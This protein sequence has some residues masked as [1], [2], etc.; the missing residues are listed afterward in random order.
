MVGLVVSCQKTPTYQKSRNARVVSADQE[1]QQQGRDDAAEPDSEENPADAQDNAEMANNETPATGPAT[2]Q[3]SA[4]TIIMEPA[5]AGRYAPNRLQA[6]WVTDMNDQHLRTIS[7]NPG[8]RPQHLR[9]WQAA[10]GNQLDGFSGATIT[11]FMA[12]PETFSWDLLDKNGAKVEYGN[13]KIWFELTQSNT[14]ADFVDGD[15]GY[16][17]YSMVFSLS[18]EGFSVNDNNHPTFTA[19]DLVH[20]P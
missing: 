14:D 11:S 19:I 18:P 9:Q 15:P 4:S 12:T 5:E 2:G 1:R 10:N 7:A 13:Y 20:T 3:L 6:V 16:A 17:V 8:R